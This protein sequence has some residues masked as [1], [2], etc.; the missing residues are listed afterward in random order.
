MSLLKG[1]LMI[2]NDCIY[3]ILRK[4]KLIKNNNLNNPSYL[5]KIKLN[6]EFIKHIIK[7]VSDNFTDLE[8]SIY[9]YI[10]LCNLLTHDINDLYKNS[11]T[12]NHKKLSRLKHININN[13]I[14][15][16]YEFVG[17][18]LELFN[19]KYEIGGDKLYGRGHTFLLVYYCDSIF[20]FDAT[21]GLI[22]CDLTRVKNN[23]RV[24]NILP[25][26]SDDEMLNELY[27]SIDN[28]YNYIEKHFGKK[29]YD[30]CEYINENKIYN[31][32]FDDKLDLFF[33]KIVNSSLPPMDNIKYIYILKK[34]L[35]YN[36]DFN[37]NLLE[38]NYENNK[39]KLLVVLTINKES[40]YI[41]YLYEYPNRF[42][43]MN[44]IEL[45]IFF[46][47]NKFKYIKFLKEEIPGIK[48]LIKN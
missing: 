10:K 16:C 44:N 4:F 39:S 47:N 31:L 11:Y 12:I 30:E 29:Y 37:I 48:K 20:S 42:Y 26:E 17:K 14:I 19:I 41:Y 22:N 1:V 24:C 32:T 8:I 7:G 38:Y 43:K 34:E 13:N 28:V 2:L 46:N 40:N 27:L 25:I 18:L 35:F 21:R 6:K 3:S 9:L 36:E 23:I 45:E 33:K 15:V 5:K